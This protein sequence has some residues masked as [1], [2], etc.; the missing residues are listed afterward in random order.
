MRSR[1]YLPSNSL[2]VAFEAVM[3]SGTTAEAA[4]A[5][6]LTQGAVSRLVKQLEEQLG[7]TLFERRQQRLIPTDA[8]RSYARDISRA[9]ES[10]ERASLELV[11]NPGGGSLSISVLPAFGSR[12][13]APRLGRFQQRHPDVALNLATRLKR[14]NLDAE[15][16]D[17]AIHFGKDD[18]RD[19]NHLKLFDERLVACAAPSL[20]ANRSDMSPG[21]L[22]QLP[23]FQIE[24]RPSAWKVWFRTHGLDPGDAHGMLFDQFAPMAEAA[25]AGSGIAL[26]P[27]YFAEREIARSE[28][29]PI[30]PNT[31]VV[32]GSYWLV[33]SDRRGESQPLSALRNWLSDELRDSAC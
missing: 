1:R 27:D 11:T 21:D 17:A 14:F 19:A 32:M 15:G 9:L 18:W 8:A 29:V 25:I 22:R 3:R 33:T 16:F 2:L 4:R 5:L 7:V 20:L 28:L 23:L 30:L 31:I 6:S 26:L 24:S 13:L 10:I 12:W